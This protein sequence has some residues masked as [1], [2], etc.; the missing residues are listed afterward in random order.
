VSSSGVEKWWWKSGKEYVPD[1]L[2]VASRSVRRRELPACAYFL[3]EIRPRLRD[4]QTCKTPCMLPREYWTNARSRPELGGEKFV[5]P[6]DIEFVICNPRDCSGRFR[7]GSV[8]QS[9]GP[10]P[11]RKPW[12]SRGPVPSLV[13]GHLTCILPE[14]CQF[15]SSDARQTVDISE[16]ATRGGGRT[17]GSTPQISQPPADSFEAAMEV[18]PL[19][20]K[21]FLG[22]GV[23]LCTLR[24]RLERCELLALPGLPSLLIAVHLFGEFRVHAAHG[25]GG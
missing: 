9:Q 7:D 15:K 17:A 25:G 3:H 12:Q 19:G 14:D 13:G 6:L 21:A 1:R 16:R 10:P 18:R 4:C 23:V 5:G 20:C 24:S 2:A 11:D 8:L 22:A